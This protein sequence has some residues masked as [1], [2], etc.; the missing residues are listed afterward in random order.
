MTLRDIVNSL[1]RDFVNYLVT[2]PGR[3]IPIEIGVE[4]DDSITGEG[5][6]RHVLE[7]EEHREE[8]AVSYRAEDFEAFRD[9][10]MRTAE[11]SDGFKAVFMARHAG[12]RPFKDISCMWRLN[13]TYFR[14]DI[15]GSVARHFTKDVKWLEPLFSYAGAAFFPR[16]G[17]YEEKMKAFDEIANRYPYLMVFGNGNAIPKRMEVGV[18]GID[19][20]ARYKVPIIPV[21]IHY[22]CLINLPR[23]GGLF[24]RKVRIVFG[25]P[26][27]PLEIVDS[28]K[29]GALIFSGQKEFHRE[30][31]NMALM[32]AQ[33]AYILALTHAFFYEKAPGYII[34]HLK[35]ELYFGR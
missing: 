4:V 15:I 17:N 23:V 18:G 6:E 13:I 8:I 35:P 14:Y 31:G 32:G 12:F 9:K 20:A 16:N 3:H 28:P 27:E 26:I 11:E 25:K 29:K 33:S 22:D 30:R 34:R 19:T 2:L 10:I 7:A 1:K 24:V 5:I 21:G